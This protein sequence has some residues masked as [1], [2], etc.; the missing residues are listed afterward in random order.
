MSLTGK[1]LYM[2]QVYEGLTYTINEIVY[3]SIDI[4]IITNL[5][6]MITDMA[7]TSMQFGKKRLLLEVFIIQYMFVTNITSGRLATKNI[8]TYTCKGK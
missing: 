8:Y 1:L 6:K 3:W 7:V 5:L 2:Y 4:K